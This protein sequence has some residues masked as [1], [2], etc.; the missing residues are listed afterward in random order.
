MTGGSNS[1]SIRESLLKGYLLKYILLSGNSI[2][3]VRELLPD[4]LAAVQFGGGSSGLELVF[5]RD[6]SSY[7]GERSRELRL[8]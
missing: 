1:S 5:I 2:G 6:D 3:L 4:S 8:A 7:I